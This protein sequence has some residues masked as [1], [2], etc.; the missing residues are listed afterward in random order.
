MTDVVVTV[1]MRFWDH[2]LA[3]GD[4]PGNEWTKR[5]YAF[6]IGGMR[7][8][9]NPGERV[10]VVAFGRLRGYAPLVR[11]DSHMAER[12]D[13]PW[14]GDHLLTYDLVRGGDAV[15]LTIPEPIIG[16]RGWRYRWWLTTREIPFPEWRTENVRPYDPKLLDVPR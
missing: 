4:L 1:P 6:S 16:F 13:P 15:A 9:I 12:K 10:Y 11:L 14:R 3:E 2:W 8:D 7:P 5:W